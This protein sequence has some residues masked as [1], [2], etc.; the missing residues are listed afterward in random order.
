LLPSI[1][2]VGACGGAGALER[3]REHSTDE[4][5]LR[6]SEFRAEATLLVGLK[7]LEVALGQRD[8]ASWIVDLEAAVE[9]VRY[10]FRG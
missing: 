3:S 5:V 2:G 6:S 4:I 7:R 10:R 1:S 8:E 9:A